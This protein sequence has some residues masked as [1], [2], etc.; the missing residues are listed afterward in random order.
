M[1]ARP[2]VLV[3]AAVLAL[4]PMLAHGHES[5][6]GSVAFGLQAGFSKLEGDLAA[7]RLCPTF[8]ARFE[9]APVPY[10]ALG[11]SASYAT[12]NSRDW[13]ERVALQWDKTFAAPV[14]AEVI[15]R[16]FPLRRFTP[17]A[18]VGAGALYWRSQW[19]DTITIRKGWDAFAKVGGGLQA[20]LTNAVTLAIG[21]DVR[22]TV[23][24]A[25]DNRAS[26]DETDGILTPHLALHFVF[27]TR[28][29]NDRDHDGVPRELDLDETIAE[30]QD[31]YMDHDGVPEANPDFARYYRGKMKLEEEVREIARQEAA[32]DTQP[33]VVHHPVRRAEHHKALTLKADVYCDSL[34]VCAAL[35]R[36]DQNSTWSVAPMAPS[37]R[38]PYRYEA[39]IP[40]SIVESGLT[41]FVAAVNAE[42][43]GLGYSGVP[44]RP[45]TVK[46]FRY[47]SR[48]R[49]VGA[50]V[51]ALGWGAA[52]FWVLRRQK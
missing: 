48:W 44:R 38:V 52:S 46:V 10:M 50:T 36:L 20:R 42:K 28:D 5:G 7:S 34:F 3:A 49:R 31:G 33:V 24:D 26:G 40:D 16:L 4:P 1:R 35:Y 2:V 47:P 22:A 23:V 6:W 41:Y 51:A 8:G 14:D 29:P 15:F 25:L 21:V 18:S 43:R 30:D 39:T 45:L 13:Q 9:Y 19:A 17:Y 12:L 32:P 11:L 37:R 27:P